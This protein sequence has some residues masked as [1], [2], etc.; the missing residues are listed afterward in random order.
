MLR[1]A[2]V[3]LT[4]GQIFGG[5]VALREDRAMSR[6]VVGP[7][8]AEDRAGSIDGWNVGFINEN[9]KAIGARLPDGM[10]AGHE[11]VAFSQKAVHDAFEDVVPHLVVQA[12]APFLQGVTDA[13]KGAVMTPKARA[14][15][16]NLVTKQ[17]FPPGT[18][19]TGKAL[20]QV[21]RT[22]Q[23][24][25][26]K[27]KVSTQAEDGPIG[28]LLSEIADHLDDL[29]V[30]QNPTQAAKFE[31]A[32]TAHRGQMI[33]DR[34]AKGTDDGIFS[35]GQAKQAALAIDP[36]KRKAASARG[37]AFLQPMITAAREVLPSKTPNSYSA[38]RLMAGKLIPML[39]GAGARVSYDARKAMADLAAQLPPEVADIVRRSQKPA[40]LFGASAPNAARER[41]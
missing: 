7:Q 24:L 41:R 11:A 18:A 22:A 33:I 2:G 16:V 1:E 36:S 23:G 3:K 26:Q 32:N 4:P 28:D 13:I 34:A 21:R 17:M 25:A 5:K 35:T 30:R 38:D 15:A 6:P 8:I 29:I 12:D 20:Q 31:A 9:L 39:S 19:Y 40:G 14:T 37:E 27:Y 10:K